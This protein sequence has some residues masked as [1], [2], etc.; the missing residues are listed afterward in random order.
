MNI[1]WFFCPHAFF[2]SSNFRTCLLS[3]ICFLVLVEIPFL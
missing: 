3:R 2:V 1:P